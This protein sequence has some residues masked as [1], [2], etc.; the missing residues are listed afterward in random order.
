[1]QKT[2]F[3][4]VEFVV[5]DKVDEYYID[6]LNKN[7]IQYKERDININKS[8]VSWTEIEYVNHKTGKTLYAYEC[9]HS[10][11]DGFYSKTFVSEHKFSDNDIY[12]LDNTLND[13]EYI[14]YIPEYKPFKGFGKGS[15]P[16]L[17][18]LVGKYVNYNGERYEFYDVKFFPE[19]VYANTFYMD[20]CGNEYKGSI[21]FIMPLGM[22]D[23]EYIFVMQREGNIPKII[24][25]NKFMEIFGE[26]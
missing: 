12:K 8:F 13:L 3:E 24:K 2:Y 25:Y 26:K 14:E 17:R 20:D 23:K 9:C 6:A 7:N 1:M 22:I 19:G 11:V 21:L 18:N 15:F 16:L 5:I 4:G 10:E